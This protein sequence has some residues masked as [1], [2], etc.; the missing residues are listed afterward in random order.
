MLRAAPF[1]ARYRPVAVA[2]QRADDLGHMPYQPAYFTVLATIAI[3]AV[4]AASVR[5]RTELVVDPLRTWYGAAR[6]ADGDLLWRRA[7]PGLTGTAGRLSLLS[8]RAGVVARMLVD[9]HAELGLLGDKLRYLSDEDAD[10]D[11]VPTVAPVMSS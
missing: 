1:A 3:R 2:D 9:D 4:L 5:G 10:E 11:P 6:R 8:V 7:L